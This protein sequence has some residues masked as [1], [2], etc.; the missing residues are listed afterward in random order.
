MRRQAT[1]GGSDKRFQ[2]GCGR[3]IDGIC[4]TE[5][6]S[7]PIAK[8]LETVKTEDWLVPSFANAKELF[9][10]SVTHDER[11]MNYEALCTEKV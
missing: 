2:R 9:V 4:G 3:D 10:E 5:L 1:L 7:I 11:E 8:S 6:R